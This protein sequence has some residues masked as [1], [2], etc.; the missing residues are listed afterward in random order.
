MLDYFVNWEGDWGY[1]PEEVRK[2]GAAPVGI[3]KAN[4]TRR[5]NAVNSDL[6]PCTRLVARYTEL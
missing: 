5:A 1:V 2:E 4:E 6:V 3:S